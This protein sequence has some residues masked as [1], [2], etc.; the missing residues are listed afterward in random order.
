[1]RNKRARAL[2]AY[3]RTQHTNYDHHEPIWMRVR[4]R[5]RQIIRVT[6]MWPIG[7]WRRIYRDLKRVD[8]RM[9]R[10]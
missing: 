6:L 5:V 8:G 10:A 4:N 2:R 1:M 7:H 3:A 9:A